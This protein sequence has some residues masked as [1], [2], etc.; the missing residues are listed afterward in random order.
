MSNFSIATE[1]E[2]QQNDICNVLRKICHLSLS[3]RGT[4]LH[5]SATGLHLK[6]PS[7]SYM[8]WLA[9]ST[10]SNFKIVAKTGLLVQIKDIK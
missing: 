8:A 7:N 3:V 10:L 5:I 2:K 4:D 9:K 1:A 6:I